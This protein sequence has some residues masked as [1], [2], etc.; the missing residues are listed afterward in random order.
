MHIGSLRVNS[1]EAVA[2]RMV[3]GKGAKLDHGATLPQDLL[4][5]R[6]KG[7][8]AGGL[9]KRCQGVDKDFK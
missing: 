9:A 2:L 4:E 1:V 3:I 8:R 6:R 5:A 7:R